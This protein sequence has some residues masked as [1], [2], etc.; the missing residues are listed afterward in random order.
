MN[1]LYVSKQGVSFTFFSLVLV[2]VTF[3]YIEYFPVSYRYS[4]LENYKEHYE[5]GYQLSLLKSPFFYSLSNFFSYLG[6]SFEAFRAILFYFFYF[7]I[8]LFFIR[9]VPCKSSSIFFL[10]SFLI[11]SFIY[12]PYQAL[13][14]L[15]LRQGLGVSFLFFSLFFSGFH[16]VRRRFFLVVVAAGF[17][18]SILFYAFP[19]LAILAF[20]GLRFVTVFYFFSVFFYIIDF[21]FYVKDI[22]SGW[23]WFIYSSYAL[24]DFD[25]N[26]GFKS[27]FLMLSLVPVV[28]YFLFFM[29]TNGSYRG[30]RD[31]LFEFYLWA[32]GLALF[33]S[34]FAYY[35][36]LLLLSWVLIPFILFFL[37]SRFRVRI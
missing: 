3:F 28:V 18:P 7:S 5:V 33:F 12:F 2:L 22:F 30:E 23:D 37:S 13:S 32:N 27:T 6:F 21:G 10:F 24:D 25:Y 8:S 11:F 1:F 19:L 26:V 4:D 16:S 35:D 9:V 29:L 17:H 31:E 14:T 20:K 34:G 15:V 36:R